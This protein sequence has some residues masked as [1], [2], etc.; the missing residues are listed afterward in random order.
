VWGDL[1]RPELT[2]RW[3]FYENRK[4]IALGAVVGTLWRAALVLGFWRDIRMENRVRPWRAVEWAAI[5]GSAGFF[6][7]TAAVVLMRLT[8]RPFPLQQAANALEGWGARLLEYCS[9][10]GFTHGP[11]WIRVVFPAVVMCPLLFVVLPY[12]RAASKVALVHVVRAAAYSIALIVSGAVVSSAL[13]MMEKGWA[14][15]KGSRAAFRWT[16]GEEF[17]SLMSLNPFAEI[18]TRPVM[19]TGWGRTYDVGELLI[20]A[21]MGG[22]LALY[23]MVALKRGFRMKDWRAVWASM[24]ACWVVLAVLLLMFDESFLRGVW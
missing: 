4:G 15:A 13:V 20:V 21:V 18:M 16:A 11:L 3:W 2:H 8:R 17:I 9:W 19:A 10:S 1:Y 24:M 22:W 12:S 23:W 5:T 14:L 6:M 7:L